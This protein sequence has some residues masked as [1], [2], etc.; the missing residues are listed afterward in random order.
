MPCCFQSC[1]LLFS[2]HALLL[3][4]LLHLVIV[5]CSN[6]FLRCALL[7]LLL[8]C[9][10]LI[11]LPLFFLR[12]AIFEVMP[13]SSCVAPCCFLHLAVVPCSSCVAPCCSGYFVACTLFLTICCSW[14]VAHALLPCH[15][16]L[17]LCFVG[18]W[19]LMFCHHAELFAFFKYLLPS[20]P[21]CFATLLLCL[22]NWYSFFTFLCKWRSLEQH[23]QASSKNIDILFFHIFLSVFFLCFVICL[24]VLFLFVICFWIEYILF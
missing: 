22:V 18:C 14:F 11:A 20:P 5:S 17:L 4:T 9:L 15:H 8:G 1:T 24:F 3:A 6:F 10:S 7:F 12:L 16:A 13:C 21:C 23:Q 19:T 2:C